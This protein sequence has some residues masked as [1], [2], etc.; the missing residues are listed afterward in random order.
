MNTLDNVKLALATLTRDKPRL[1]ICDEYH[2]GIHADPYMPD[3][4]GEEYRLL[5]E[6]A[7]TN[8]LSLIVDATA[9]ALIVDN[10]QRHTESGDPDEEGSKRDWGHW[11]R[12]R[13]DA[14]QSPIIR[15]AVTFG[16]SFVLTEKDLAGNPV[17]RG[18]SPLRTVTMYEDPTLDSDPAFAIY[19]RRNP[20]GDQA[21]LI[22]AWDARF[23]YVFQYENGG[24]V[25]ALLLRAPHGAKR[26]PVTRI[27]CYTDLEGNT[28]GLIEPLIEIQDRI[29]Q[30][31]FDLLV[32]QSYTS[33]EVRTVTGQAPPLKMVLDPDTGLRMPELDAEGN[34]IP[35]TLVVNAQ[36]WIY[37][38]NP[39]AK[40]GHLPAGDL[41][42]IIEAIELGQRHLSAIAQVPPHYMLGQISNVNAEGLNAAA[43]QLARKNGEIATNIGEGFERMFR[44]AA[45]MRGESVRDGDFGEVKWRD[46]QNASIAQTADALNK[47]KD[48]GVP[49]RGLW[50]RIPG[51]TRS[52]IE[53]WET[54]YA[55]ERPVLDLTG[56]GDLTL[57]MFEDDAYGSE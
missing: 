12:S 17:S 1:Q 44:V 52:E 9:Q 55:D 35:D 25:G 54:F 57:D 53:D 3:S 33:F 32:A 6:R 23:K 49:V 50:R 18:I 47:F 16:H 11:Q 22:W 13:L 14:G 27:P 2:K 51:V 38:E 40:F 46:L 20:T 24:E 19:I 48:L 5:A 26:C 7:T 37:S 42:S 29:N 45:E 43:V 4:A 21:G 15:G 56:V 36:R 39:D 34:P 28:T 30:S 10:F 31:V 41:R 8:W